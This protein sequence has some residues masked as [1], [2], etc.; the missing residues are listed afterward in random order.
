MKRM[1][2]SLPEYTEPPVV[3]PETERNPILDRI[4]LTYSYP[5]EFRRQARDTKE[6]SALSLVGKSREATEFGKIDIQ[7]G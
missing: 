6:P 3:V 2:D 4:L 5:D 7:A 1:L